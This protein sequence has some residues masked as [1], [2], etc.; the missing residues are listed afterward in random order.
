MLIRL[1]GLAII[2]YIYL[3]DRKDFLTRPLFWTETT[4]TIG[5]VVGLIMAIFG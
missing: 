4:M 2:Y 1:F 3:Q 5:V